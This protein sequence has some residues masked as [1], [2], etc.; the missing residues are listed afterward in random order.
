MGCKQ[1][2]AKKKP[3]A[4]MHKCRRCGA[5]AKKSKTL[6]KPKKIKDGSA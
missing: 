5:V 3:K 4:G 2:K 6:C 1:G